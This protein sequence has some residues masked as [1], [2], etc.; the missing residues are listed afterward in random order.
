MHFFLYVWV[1][2]QNFSRFGDMHF[3]SVS[4]TFTLGLSLMLSPRKTLLDLMKGAVS[5]FAVLNDR[6]V[7]EDRV[8][9]LARV[10]VCVVDPRCHHNRGIYSIAMRTG[11]CSYST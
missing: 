2:Q 5:L 1:H 7:R 10:R 3:C 6:A 4:N 8:R 9:R 11:Y